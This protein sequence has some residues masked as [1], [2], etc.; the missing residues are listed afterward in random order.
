MDYKDG[1][2]IDDGTLFPGMLVPKCVWR[3]SGG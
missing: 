1:T 3:S 2:N